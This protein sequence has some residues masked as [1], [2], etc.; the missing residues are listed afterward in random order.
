MSKVISIDINSFRLS[1]TVVL[2]GI[3][4]SVVPVKA[5]E[6]PGCFMREHSGNVENLTQSVCG[7][8]PTSTPLSANPTTPGVFQIPIK[9]RQGG[10]PVIDVNFNGQNTF[11]MLL[12][13]GATGVVITPAMANALKVQP[14]GNL[15]INTASD[16]LVNQQVGRV[17]SINVGGLQMSNV[18]VSISPVLQIGLL[19]QGFFG[20][21][22][23]TIKQDVIEFRSRA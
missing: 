10:I 9:R 1:L 17:D 22:D 16:Q 8:F 19:G 15:P 2:T 18:E 14:Y 7:L 5:Q 20:T 3:L 6:Y 21:Y 13:T 4:L 23:I 11:E 12:D